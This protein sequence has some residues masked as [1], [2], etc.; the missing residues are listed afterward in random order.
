MRNVNAKIFLKTTAP[1]SGY[2][3]SY[4]L[5]SYTTALILIN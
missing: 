5:K 1:L 2:W 4:Q 3:V